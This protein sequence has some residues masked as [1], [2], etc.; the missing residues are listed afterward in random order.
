M[1]TRSQLLR[2]RY[3]PHLVLLVPW[4]L[5]LQHIE[6]FR[7]RLTQPALFTLYLVLR[8]PCE[9]VVNGAIGMANTR[10]V[11]IL[12]TG[13]DLSKKGHVIKVES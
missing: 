2:Q 9:Q 5:Q 6:E 11:D 10:I 7:L 13:F 1:H 8:H 3:E 4:E 12:W